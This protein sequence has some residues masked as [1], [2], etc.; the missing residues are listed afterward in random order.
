[1]VGSVH[2]EILAHDSQT[3]EAKVSTG[4]RLR[5][6][7]DIDAGQARTVVSPRFLS[8]DCVMISPLYWGCMDLD[9]GGDEALGSI[10]SFERRV[11]RMFGGAVE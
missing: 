7:A 6:S 2:D 8:I 4:L 3:N 5:G 11:R 10:T 1:M 9:G